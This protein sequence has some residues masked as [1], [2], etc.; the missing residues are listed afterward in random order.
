[1]SFGSFEFGSFEFGSGRINMIKFPTLSVKPSTKKFDHSLLFDPIHRTRF[2]SGAILTR[3]LFSHTPTE[4][5]ISYSLMPA[6]DKFILATWAKDDIANG[7]LRFE[8]TLPEEVCEGAA[9]TWVS[10]LLKPIIYKVHPKSKGNYW[11]VNFSIATIY[12]VV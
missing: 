6:A 1:M 7:G 4:Y 12:E 11:V 8:F 2:G 9:E 5:R 3:P 10:V